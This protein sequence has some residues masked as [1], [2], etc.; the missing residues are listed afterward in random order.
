MISPRFRYLVPLLA[1]LLAQ[2]CQRESEG[3]ALPEGDAESGKRVFVE[4]RCNDC[5]SVSD[6]E[7]SESE[8]PVEYMGKQTVGKIHV[9]LGG[10]TTKYRT[11]GE[12]V[13]SI[14]NPSHEISLSY[15][16]NQTTTRSPMRNYNGV[17][18]VQNLIDL[19][20]FL[21]EEYD[22]QSARTM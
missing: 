1:T 22:I 21:Q 14:I 20:A 3:F 15:A 12:L 16:R 8:V 17:L 7:Y 5:H 9:K 19:V 11:Q 6:I 10:K 4:I 13:T 2:G 18:T